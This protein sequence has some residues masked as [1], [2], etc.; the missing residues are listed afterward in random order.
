MGNHRF[1][2][3]LWLLP[4]LAG[5]VW[6]FACVGDTNTQASPC[7]AYC[8][9]IQSVCTGVD[10]QYPDL[11]TCQTFCRQ[12]APGTPAQG[13]ADTVAC[14]QLD[15]SSAKDAVSDA[16]K[17]A[18]CVGAG[19]ATNCGGSQ[20]AAFCKLN[21]SMCGGVSSYVTAAGCEAACKKWGTS[22]DGKLLG[23][24]GDTLQCRTYH[25]EL[26]QTGTPQDKTTHCPHTDPVSARCFDADAGAGD[27][28]GDAG[29]SDAAAD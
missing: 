22:F 10:Q 19:I 12:M 14:R 23:S 26:S 1:L 20:C 4:A 24:T 5:G 27:G 21:L 11:A 15:V 13:G 6:L 2:R 25:M 16:E 8:N 29:A 9:D 17:H 7:D 18:N 28:G 3:A